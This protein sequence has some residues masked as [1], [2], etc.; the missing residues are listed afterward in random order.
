MKC[1]CLILVMSM[2]IHA[3]ETVELPKGTGVAW[4]INGKGQN[5]IVTHGDTLK[6]VLDGATFIFKRQIDTTGDIVYINP[7]GLL[8]FK[9]SCSGVL[10]TYEDGKRSVLTNGG[11]F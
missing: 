6:I 2:L 3:Q 8:F 4:S 9:S 11:C 5:T 10:F 1:L 7:E